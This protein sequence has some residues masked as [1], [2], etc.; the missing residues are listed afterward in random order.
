M[1]DF[2]GHDQPLVSVMMP[3]YNGEKTIM[4]AIKSLLTQTYK[5]WLCVI[6]NDGSTDST[7]SI[8]DKIS[9]DRFKI[10][11]L[12][13]NVGRG[14]ARQIALDNSEGEYLAFLDA[15]DFYH[16]DKLLRQV[17]FLNENRNLSLVS[18]RM[19]VFDS[20]Y[21]PYSLRG[22]IPANILLY[23]LGDPIKISMPTAMVRLPEAKAVKYNP[24]FNASEDLDFF[25]KYLNNRYYQNIP[26]V[27]LYYLVSEY[28]NSYS[29]IL[30]YTSYEIMYGISLFVDN[31]VASIRIIIK[32]T[33]KWIV[34]SIFIPLFGSKFFLRRR[35][36]SLPE[37]DKNIFINQKKKLDRL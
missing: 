17:M 25:S 31:K 30:Q 22:V 21:F 13:E 5:N 16:E 34:F 12:S 28:S 3:V 29:K 36:N 26:E 20:N 14:A 7:R 35:G 23:K 10:I 9:D 8:L 32:S 4:L 15:D 24:K 2:S 6:V 19:V 1:A 11:H 37:E 27:V 33:I 18:G